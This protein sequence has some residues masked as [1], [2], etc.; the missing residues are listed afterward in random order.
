MLL[1][2]WTLTGCVNWDGLDADEDGF[3]ASEGDCNDVDPDIGPAA[4][5]IWYD[6]IDQNCDGNDADQDE[7]GYLSVA[8]GGDDCWDD[9]TTIPDS[10]TIVAGQGFAQ[11]SAFDVNPGAE[12][13]WYDGID[14]NCDEAGDFDQDG[15]GHDA[16]SAVQHDGTSG[17]DCVDS[18][19][20]LEAL[21][22][23][24][25]DG[26]DAADINPSADPTADD[27]YDGINLDCD[28]RE[29]AEDNDT[30]S[31]DSDFDCDQD[32][33]MADQD[34]DDSDPTAVP[35]LSIEEI[36]YD[37]ID[38]NCDG[39]DGDQDGDGWIPDDYPD[40][41]PDW[42]ELHGGEQA[43][44]ELGDCW[45]GG[46]VIPSE[47]LALN[48][49]PQ[50]DA[51]DVYPGA[52]DTWYDGIDA[53]CAGDS[54]FDA[55]GDGQDTDSYADRDGSTGTDCDDSEGTIYLGATEYCDGIDRDCDGLIDDDDDAVDGI[56]YYY[57]EDDDG[58]GTSASRSSCEPVGLY[59]ADNP[60]DCDDTDAATYPGAD[61]YCDTEDRD[62]D[63]AVDE[64]HAV[65][66]S[67]WYTDADSD[68]YG[69]ASTEDIECYAPSGTVADA[70]DCD[71]TDDTVHPTASELCDGQLNDCDGSGVPADETDD[72]GDGVVECT[73]DAGGWDGDAAVTAGEDCDD[74]EAT[75]YPG[76]SE[77]CDGQI[78]DCDTASL[79]SDESDDDSDGHVECTFDAGGWDGTAAVTGDEDCED[80]DPTRYP[81][82]PELCDG[83]IND[84]DSSSLPSDETDDDSDGF[85]EC[86]FDG[87]GWDGSGD[88]IGDED[89]DAADALSYPGGTETCDGL[90]DEDCDGSVDE[91]SAVD[92][93]TWYRDADVDG[94]GDSADTM[95]A[96][97]LP[98]G[99]V[100][101]AT[102]CDDGDASVNPGASEV[103]DGSTDEDCDTVVD[104]DGA[105]DV[106]TW[107]AD[108]DGDGFGD[109]STTD[110]DCDQPTN[111]VS[112]STDCDDADGNTWPGA[113][114]ICDGL[115]ND[116]DGAGLPSD[117]SD[118]DSDG[119][120]E[121]TFHT[122]G[123]QGT[124]AVT[125]D[126]DCDDAEPTVYPGAAELC[127][128]QI[129][130]CDTSSLPADESD[131]DADGYSEC[132][133]DAG[134]WDGSASVTGDEDCDD[135]DPNSFPGGTE[136]C[137]G[138]AD[139]DCDGTVDEAGATGAPTWYVDVDGDGYGDASLSQV[140]CS[141]PSGYADNSD[142]CDDGEETVYP[143]AAE[144]CDGQL[145][146]CT[147]S[148]IPSDE[149]DDDGD[150]YVECE[151][152][153]DGWDGSPDVFDDEDCDDADP[154]SHPGG[155]ETC[156]GTADEDC[157]GL[158]DESG[159]SWSVADA[160]LIIDGATSNDH[161]GFAVDAGGDL[162]GDGT[163]VLVIGGYAYNGDAGAVWLVPA[164]T[165]GNVDLS[166]TGTRIDGAVAGGAASYDLMAGGDADGDGQVDLMV[167]AYNADTDGE[168]YLVTGPVTGNM[169]LS[170]ATAT[171][172]S[173]TGK[174]RTG[175]AVGFL[176]AQ[177]GGTTD[178]YLVGSDKYDS[179][180]K[181]AGQVL[182][183]SGVTG[184]LEDEDAQAEIRGVQHSELLGFALDG[185]GDLD[186]DGLGD[187]LLGAERYDAGSGTDNG[188]V[189]VFYG[190]VSGSYDLDDAAETASGP[191]GAR[192]GQS[193]DLGTDVDGDGLDDAIAGGFEDG[194]TFAT[195]GVAY[196]FTGTLDSGP[197]ATIVPTGTDQDVGW[198]V[199]LGGDVNGDGVGDVLVG[200]PRVDATAGTNSGAAYV[201]YGPVV[202]TVGVDAA[203]FTFEGRDAG[204]LAG[205]STAFVPD[206]DGD[207]ADEILV[208]SEKD[209]T[210]DNDRGSAALFLTTG[211]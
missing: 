1:L 160:S 146:N 173:A 181:D 57:D 38:Q 189:V 62:C 48:G 132:A 208:G 124:A 140:S 127:D 205:T 65:D 170:S 179:P 108:T 28:A 37:G 177:D 186:G 17:D 184:T 86:T 165:T 162:T 84:C 158:V 99:Y 134:G 58:Y 4:T 155:T 157:D 194:S 145:N 199:R 67:A 193:L 89:C 5:E 80:T 63:G 36:W 103:C 49:L 87:G 51:M 121:C 13:T 46:A 109:A 54:D 197:T 156:D 191:H 167:G 79:P 142:D 52:A 12:E 71:D 195:G 185:T 91:A 105:I 111:F 204:A 118:D 176:W 7:D 151:F 14:G 190:P 135:A 182:V 201:F 47:F 119:V 74:A 163:E 41:C 56:Q 115:Q 183:F 131:A 98:S 25:P 112:D 32:G 53:D 85:V 178:A 101:D 61:E 198:S 187:L 107:Y 16:A 19:E 207:G 78:N 152:D 209:G 83:L 66:A 114:E 129:N 143:S 23:E 128:G 22:V 202:G 136:V 200:A 82:A 166:T 171:V 9:P 29:P 8:V 94:Y 164:T 133:W 70:S 15:D 203:D 123:W 68:G 2:L 60:D 206:V 77:L 45:D 26:I 55:D 137:D 34:C 44:V 172:V 97:S 35:D 11:P 169:D 116:C 18:A 43:T 149:T 100:A 6:G 95:L 174:V 88:V 104:E 24:I 106:A 210:I 10:Y 138:S 153:V 126:E 180:L 117:E 93:E 141:A 175:I 30:T 113:G 21:G 72:D 59:R 144:L 40:Q 159:C 92:A 147:G 3:K 211:L 122:D 64:D 120:V 69:D 96:C 139:E 150:T 73:L 42:E 148:G 81:G 39:N 130:D 168:A 125:A 102:D 75:K 110:I 76:A 20:E 33:W 31:W 192:L 188:R 154:L 161:A 196:L 50:V 90:A 27:C